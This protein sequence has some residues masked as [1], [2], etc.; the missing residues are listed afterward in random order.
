MFYPHPLLSLFFGGGCHLEVL[1]HAPPDG[2]LMVAS[3]Q[4]A[5]GQGQKLIRGAFLL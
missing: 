1:T 4:P 5:L 2:A 3:Q